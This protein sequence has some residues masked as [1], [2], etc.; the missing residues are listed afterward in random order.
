MSFRQS[1]AK[2]KCTAHRIHAELVS[3]LLEL[4]Y[5]SSENRRSAMPFNPTKASGHINENF[6]KQLRSLPARS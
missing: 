1:K 4:P 6:R 5:H 2:V 3:A